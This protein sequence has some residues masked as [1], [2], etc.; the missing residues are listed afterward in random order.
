MKNDASS[1]FD[2]PAHA[3]SGVTTA[4]FYF[5]N[6]CSAEQAGIQNQS[7]QQY[8]LWSNPV[9]FNIQRKAFFCKLLQLCQRFD[10]VTILPT[11]DDVTIMRQLFTE[12]IDIYF[13]EFC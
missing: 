13:F 3:Y 11:I 4:F 7:L 12:V 8:L 2:D 9:L 1:F 6:F 10:D 5:T